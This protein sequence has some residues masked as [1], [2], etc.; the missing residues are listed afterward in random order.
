MY[1]SLK[2]DYP[3]KMFTSHSIATGLAPPMAGTVAFNHCKKF[4]KGIILVTDEE[5]KSA[6]KRLFENGLK[7]EPSGSAAMAAVLSNKIPNVDLKNSNV[8]KLKIVS[9][10]SGGNVSADELAQIFHD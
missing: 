4:V 8:D 5:I 7:V 3:V 6:C 10:I 9:I 1:E 2:N